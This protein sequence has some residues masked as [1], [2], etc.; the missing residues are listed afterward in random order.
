MA[1]AKAD[2]TTKAGPQAKRNENAEILEY[3]LR[4]LEKERDEIQLRIDGIRRQ[5]SKKPAGRP[6]LASKSETPAAGK[7]VLSEAARRRI[8]AAQKKRWAAHRKSLKAAK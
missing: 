2:V 4:H 3:A 7:R 1:K 5:L 8:A 6:P